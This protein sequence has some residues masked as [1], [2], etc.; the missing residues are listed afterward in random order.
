MTAADIEAL[1]LDAHRRANCPLW[2][3]SGRVLARC[4]GI[5]VLEDATV[6][7]VMR[8]DSGGDVVF[9]PPGASELT[10]FRGVATVLLNASG[11]AYTR[12][13]AD[14]LALALA[15][16]NDRAHAVEWFVRHIPAEAVAERLATLR[17]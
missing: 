9:V 7:V 13:D 15:I 4:L 14:R 17:A 16:P 1:A 8:S 12:A 5:V 10:V 6:A 11:R 3:P 2:F